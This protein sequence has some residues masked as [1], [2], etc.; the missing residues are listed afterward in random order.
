MKILEKHAPSKQKVYRANDKPYMTK[1]LRRAIMLR[2]SMKNKYMKYK[3]PDLHRAY[4]KQKNFTNRLLQ[5][6]RK[7]FFSNLD[8]KK[9]TDNKKF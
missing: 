2:S 1:A 5:K 3:T 4:K 7:L 6:E 8:L 9:I